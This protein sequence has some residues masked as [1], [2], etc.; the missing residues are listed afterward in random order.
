MRLVQK[1]VSLVSI[2]LLL[3]ILGSIPAKAQGTGTI[4]QLDEICEIQPGPSGP[5]SIFLFK[6]AAEQQGDVVMV[7]HLESSG[8]N[9]NVAIYSGDD[10]SIDSVKRANEDRPHHFTLKVKKSMDTTIHAHFKSDAEQPQGAVKFMSVLDSKGYVSC[11][12]TGAHSVVN[13][14]QH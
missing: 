13:N 7:C 14:T 4:C 11:S 3:F 8:E 2:L 10:L 5:E 1:M 6:Q 12:L 9:F